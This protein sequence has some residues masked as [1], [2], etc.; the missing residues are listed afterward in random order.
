M[1]TGLNFNKRVNILH[2][3][4]MLQICTQTTVTKQPQKTEQQQKS[5]QKSFKDISHPLTD[6]LCSIQ[7]ELADG[8]LRS[9]FLFPFSNAV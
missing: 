8:M 4:Q 7:I 2:S 5:P 3:A 1:L 9:L 6:I